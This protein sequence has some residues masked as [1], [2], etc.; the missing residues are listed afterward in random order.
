MSSIEYF[1]IKF[2]GDAGVTGP[3]GKPSC[4]IRGRQGERGPPGPP[5]PHMPYAILENLVC[6][7]LT[8]IDENDLGGHN[9]LWHDVGPMLKKK[10][11]L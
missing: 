11:K 3:Q 10:R 6:H 7:M 2:I 1:S 8:E 5:G 9:N 4:G